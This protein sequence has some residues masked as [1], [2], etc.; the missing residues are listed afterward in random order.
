MVKNIYSKDILIAQK[1]NLNDI[2]STNFPT[3][4]NATFQFGV[5]VVK[6][7]K[8]LV[9]HI[10]KRVERTID[11]TSEFLFVLSG[12]MLIDIYDEDELFIEKIVL[13]NNE[14][15][16]QFIGGHAITLKENTKYFEIKQGPYYGHDFD[17]YELKANIE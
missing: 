15:L 2:N 14:C 11:T 12:E 4:E 9:P 8:V 7:E 5:G 1:Y 6:E 17:K 16:L 10:H 13:Q 3:P